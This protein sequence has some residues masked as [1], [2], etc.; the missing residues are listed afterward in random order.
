ML[1]LLQS[2][3]NNLL[4]NIF[5]YEKSCFSSIVFIFIQKILL[6]FITKQP[7]KY[8]YLTV[9]NFKK[10]NWRQKRYRSVEKKITILKVL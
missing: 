9:I 10:Y 8:T 3:L 4:I 2:M 6:Y 1:T 7:E 5:R